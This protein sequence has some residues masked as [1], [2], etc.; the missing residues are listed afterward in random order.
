MPR[1]EVVF[2]NNCTRCHGPSGQ[3]NPDI[4]APSIAGLPGWYVETQ[5]SNFRG[6]IRGAHSDDTEGLRMRP[7]A[8]A[9]RDTD[10]TEVATHVANLKPHPVDYSAVE[11]DPERGETLY[12]TCLA[13]HGPEGKGMK[14]LH[15]PPIGQVYP[16]YFKTQIHKFQNG[17][18]GAHPKDTWG[19][20]MV[21]MSM[22]LTSEQDVNDVI[23]YI[24]TLP[25]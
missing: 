7:M 10:V 15:A 14:A 12:A 6:G 24:A 3:G 17:V 5:L 9:I 19:A 25:K 18:R 2:T 21:P 4:A 20:T 1:G 11:G 13:C 8:R 22:T 23:S 16:W